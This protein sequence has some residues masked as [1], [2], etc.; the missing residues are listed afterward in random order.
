MERLSSTLFMV[1][2]ILYYVPKAL[3]I[4]KKKYLKSHIVI[5]GISI[6]AM[7]L[8]LIERVGQPDFIKYVGF[9]IIMILIGVSG[10]LI[11]KNPKLYRKL[12][13]VFTI[14]FFVY[15]FATIVIF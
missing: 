5:G 1:A 4:K 2:L 11:K 8:A 13:I 9:T 7:V 3:K 12:H 15:L 10:Y 6:I 14:V